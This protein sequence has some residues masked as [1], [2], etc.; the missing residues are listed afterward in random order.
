MS[1]LAQKFRHLLQRR[2]R[3]RRLEEEM[4]THIDLL[5]EE[6]VLQGLDRPEARKASGA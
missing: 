2:A 5:T 4:Q 3:V 6:G 1:R